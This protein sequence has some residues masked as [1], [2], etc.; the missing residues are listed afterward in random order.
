MLDAVRR[1]FG[2]RQDN[3]AAWD[4]AARGRTL[5]LHCWYLLCFGIAWDMA[6]PSIPCVFG[7][8]LSPS[9]IMRYSAVQ[10]SVCPTVCVCTGGPSSLSGA[11]HVQVTDAVC[12]TGTAP[13]TRPPMTQCATHNSHTAPQPQRKPSQTLS[14]AHHSRSSARPASSGRR[15]WRHSTPKPITGRSPAGTAQCTCVCR[16]R[17]RVRLLGAH[18]TVPLHSQNPPSSAQRNPAQQQR[19]RPQAKPSC[20][21]GCYCCQLCGH[22]RSTLPPLHS[23]HPWRA[24]LGST[25]RRTISWRGSGEA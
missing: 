16:S 19:K 23:L 15:S 3:R 13:L 14:G 10:Q 2:A 5:V 9:T 7:R 8:W 4:T 18:M 17:R 22:C 11:S 12:T 21:G 6:M 24:P 20:A 25:W 1:H